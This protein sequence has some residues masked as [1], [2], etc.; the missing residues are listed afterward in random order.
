MLEITRLA[1]TGYDVVVI[2]TA[3]TGH[4]LRFMAAPGAVALVADVLDA[5]QEPHRIIRDQL[6]RVGRTE[7][8]DEL[9]AMLAKQAAGASAS[10]RSAKMTAFAWVTLAE[11]LAVAESEDGIAAL[12]RQGIHVTDL[13]VNRLL[14]GADACPV[15]RARRAEELRTLATIRG[16]LAAGRRLTIVPALLGEPRGVRALATVGAYLGGR[17][18]VPPAARRTVHARRS[19]RAVMSAPPAAS[20]FQLETTAGIRHARV[21]FVGGKG[22][23]GKTTVAAALALRLASTKPSRSLLL[24]STDPAHS[25]ADV[26]GAPIGDAAVPVRGAPPNLSVR[27]IDAGRAFREKRAAFEGAFGEVGALANRSVGDSGNA[28]V[29]AGASLDQAAAGLFDLAPPG[30][31]ELFGMLSVLDARAAYDIVIIDTAPT[32][33]ALRLLA[34]PDAARDWVQTL[35]RLLLK[36]RALVRPGQLAAELVQASRSIRELQTAMR[37]RT[38]TRFVVVTRAARLPR[39]ETGRLL[40]HLRALKIEPGAVI[41]N[42]RTLAPGPCRRCRATARAE[43]REV[44]ALRTPR[45]CAIIQ[46]PLVSPPPRGAAA[47]NRWA[48]TWTA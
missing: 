44:A 21:I 17:R 3:P 20:A 14:V 9:I 30:I 46:T 5:L 24:L 26:F 39:A 13:V 40:S 32:G 38:A 29:V 31:D 12:T 11:R 6:A 15:C 41:V 35:I 4:A 2:D 27:E 47:L 7:A 22:G 48:Q 45:N 37:D 33:H 18:A 16:S 23:V 1:E 43:Q 36:Y 34:M 8:A 19:R 42:A 10:L 28:L 25:L